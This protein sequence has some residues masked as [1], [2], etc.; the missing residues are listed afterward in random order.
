MSRAR[1][2]RVEYRYADNHSIGCRRSDETIAINRLIIR[3]FDQFP[4]LRPRS[5][6]PPSSEPPTRWQAG[7]AGNANVG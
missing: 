6:K 1:T 4:E 2:W 7:C 5:T 3:E